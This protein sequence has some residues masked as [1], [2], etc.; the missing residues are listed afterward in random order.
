MLHSVD[1]VGNTFPNTQY[2][3]SCVS[4]VELV[5]L[6]CPSSIFAV[7]FFRS[8]KL[9]QES[10]NTLCFL[11]QNKPPCLLIIRLLLEPTCSNYWCWHCTCLALCAFLCKVSFL[12][13]GL[14]CGQK[15]LKDTD[16]VLELGLL[17]YTRCE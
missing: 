1:F 10:Y 6:S 17:K 5:E 12:P 7:R 14:C 11:S 3:R 8:V 4:C 13:L 9:S 16:T 2:A 15:R